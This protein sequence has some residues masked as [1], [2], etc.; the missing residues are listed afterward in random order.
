MKKIF[1]LICIFLLAG[2]TSNA[3]KQ[4]YYISVAD[5]LRQTG[6]LSAALRG[7]HAIYA[8][9]PQD[10]RNYYGFACALAADAQYAEAFRYLYLTTEAEPSLQPLTDPALL[11]LRDNSGWGAYENAVIKKVS[12]KYG[13]VKNE[14]VARQLWQLK[15][16]DALYDREIALLSNSM[17]KDASIINLLWRTKKD[18][19]IEN[20]KKL[21]AIVNTIGWPRISVVGKEAA[22]AACVIVTHADAETKR[23]YLPLIKDACSEKDAGWDYYAFIYDQVQTGSHKKQLYGTQVAQDFITG[24]YSLLPIE[25]AANADKRRQ[26]LGLQPL[27][28]Y[29]AQW[30]INYSLPTK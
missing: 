13:T 27:A 29:L 18:I 11:N 5:S 4:S 12:A 20:Q 28:A 2:T 22:D 14:A 23:K 19:R 9:N 6:N 10:V 7:Y 3:Q 30:N 21:A 25:D 17:G 8:K 26:E 15:A 16:L 1:T 24:K